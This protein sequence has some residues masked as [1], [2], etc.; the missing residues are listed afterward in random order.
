[1]QTTGDILSILSLHVRFGETHITNL[2]NNYKNM[3]ETAINELEY[4]GQ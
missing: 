4:S 3:N 1:M 2:K